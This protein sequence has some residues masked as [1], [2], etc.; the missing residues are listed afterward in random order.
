MNAVSPAS[1]VEQILSLFPQVKTTGRHYQ[2]FED[3]EEASRFRSR[4]MDI[5]GHNISVFQSGR[6]V[7]LDP[8]EGSPDYGG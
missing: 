4:M 6:R 5:H 2:D 7:Y 8:K 3:A 1:E